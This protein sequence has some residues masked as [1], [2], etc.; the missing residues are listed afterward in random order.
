MAAVRGKDT[1]PEW[2]LRRELHRRGMRYRLHDRQ[3]PGCPDLTFA[4]A[5]LAVF[6]DGDFWH[7]HG[8]QQ[9]GFDSWQAQFAGHRDP[10][11]WIA[12]IGRNIER[13]REVEQQL[14]ALRWQVVRVL[15]SE[16]ASDVVAAA[17][18]VV[19]ALEIAKRSTGRR[20]PDDAARQRRGQPQRA[21]DAP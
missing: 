1:A 18:R 21:P 7:G 16:I 4:K 11:K 17:D 13:D 8:W 9:R 3:L 19:T 6:V 2:R 5:K 20:D 10:H 12:K 15:E 14:A